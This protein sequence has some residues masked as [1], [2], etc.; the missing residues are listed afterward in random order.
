MSLRRIILD[1]SF[2]YYFTI[3]YTW[4]YMHW[5]GWGS[6]KASWYEVGTDTIDKVEPNSENVGDRLKKKKEKK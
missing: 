6:S 2:K 1:F 4:E 5:S 3:P